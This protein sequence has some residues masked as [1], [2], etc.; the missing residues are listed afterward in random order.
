MV[1]ASSTITAV[2]AVAA[3]TVLGEASRYVSVWGLSQ[4]TP[5]PAYN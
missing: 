4:I 3:P 1:I 2:M 5:S